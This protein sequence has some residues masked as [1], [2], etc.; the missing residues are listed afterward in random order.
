[1]RPVVNQAHRQAEGGL[2]A[3]DAG[4]GEVELDLL[5]GDGV[6]RVVRR[7]RIDHAVAQRLDA[8]GDVAVRA[9]RRIHLGVGVV[10]DVAVAVRAAVAVGSG[11]RVRGRE[12]DLL[13]G[14]GEVVRRDLGGDVHAALACG[15]DQ[16]DR[17]G[18]GDVG[19]VQVRPG[20]VREGDIARDERLL[21]A[22][23][24]AAQTEPGG[25]P[26][27]VHLP[28]VNERRVFAVLRDRQPEGARVLQ[29]VAH[30]PRVGNGVAVVGERDDAGLRQLAGG[31]ELLAGAVARDAAER[32]HAHGGVFLGLAQHGLDGGAA[33]ERR[34]RVRHRADGGEATARGRGRAAG[35]RLLVFEAGLAQV[36]VQVHEAGRHDQPGRVDAVRLDHR[37]ALVRADARDAAVDDHDVGDAV[38]PEGRV[39][40]AAV[41]DGERAHETASPARAAAVSRPSASR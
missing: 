17:A 30:Q 27:L 22:G 25:D 21:G 33:V 37:V 2:E 29:R 3:A 31:R 14:E 39:D 1:M 41:V 16:R 10:A 15:A 40:H 12:A 18:G 9:Q 6:R 32:Q 8:G 35:D 23:G 5:V 7:D 28:L 24:A 38:A 34:V 13:M 4:C 26:A 20:Q 11:V 36:D 19:D